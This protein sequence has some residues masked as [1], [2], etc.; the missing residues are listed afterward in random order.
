M[1]FPNGFRFSNSGLLLSLAVLSFDTEY[2]LK[3]FVV[4]KLRKYQKIVRMKVIITISP[5]LL[6]RKLVLRKKI[7]FQKNKSR[8]RR[9]Q[10]LDI[11]SKL[12]KVKLTIFIYALKGIARFNSNII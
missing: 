7:I 10:T 8:K 4:K 9:H 3:I 11:F 1:S 6:R 12:A 5:L 2:F